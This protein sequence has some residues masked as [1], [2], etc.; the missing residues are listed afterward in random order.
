MD[1]RRNFSGL[2]VSKFLTTFTPV[3]NLPF[4][5]ARRS[6]S[7][8]HGSFSSFII[9]LAIGATAI[10]VAVMVLAVAFIQGFK[11][12]IRE[13]IFSFWGHVVITNYSENASEFNLTEPIRYD[14]YLVR[15]MS[16]MVHVR[17]VS[18]FIVRPAILIGRREPS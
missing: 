4:F 7:R 12:E 5:I 3:L 1:C 17:Q 14:P 9:R 10:S 13:K 11:Y 15:Q 16:E 2:A 6:F 18:P 8:Q